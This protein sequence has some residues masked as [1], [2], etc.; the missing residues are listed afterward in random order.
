MFVVIRLRGNTGVSR[1]IED[2]LKM[3][4]LKASNNCVVLPET[5]SMKGMI[6]KVKDYVTYGT[7]NLETFTALL[8][9]RGKLEGDMQ[10]TDKDAQLLGCKTVDELVKNIF[11]GKIKMK[12]AKLKRTFRLTPPAHGFKDI[13]RQ[14]PQGDLGNRGD[15]INELIERMI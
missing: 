1:R 10:L 14:Y 12:D 5:E 15:A 13:S 6:N 11:E 4:N 2:T 8:K 3:L 9:K 7:V